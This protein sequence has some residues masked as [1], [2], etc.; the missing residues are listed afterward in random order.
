MRDCIFSHHPGHCVPQVFF[1]GK[2][3]TLDGD[4][5]TFMLMRDNRTLANE[6]ELVRDHDLIKRVH[7]YGIRVP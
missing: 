3:N 6:V 2:Y 7:Q 5:A 1:D 4:M